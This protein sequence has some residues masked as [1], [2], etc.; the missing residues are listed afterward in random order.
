MLVKARF[1]FPEIL[2]GFL[3]A[4]AI[5]AMGA[6]FESSHQQTSKEQSDA[7]HQHAETNG[8]SDSKETQSLWEPT[9]AVGLY[10]LVLCGFTGLL[11]IVSIFQGA[12]L[13][14]ADKTT[15]IGQQISH[16]VMS[17]EKSLRRRIALCEDQVAH[18]AEARTLPSLHKDIDFSPARDAYRASLAKM[19]SEIQQTKR[20]PE[21]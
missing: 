20:R 1:H 2:F 18:D 11:A 13:L 5:L 14:R 12:L 16:F 3:L 6:T 19:L 8:G 10:T 4:V 9:D 17:L 15:R 7:T 21:T